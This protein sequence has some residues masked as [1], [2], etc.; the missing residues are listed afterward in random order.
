MVYESDFYTTRRPYS[1]SSRP[2]VSSYSV[3]VRSLP[4][5]PYTA[6]R[7]LVTIVRTVP[8]RIYHA[9]AYWPVVKTIRLHAKV[10]PSIIAAELNRI[11]YLTRPSFNSYVEQYLNSKGFTDFD[12]EAKDIRAKTAKLLRNIHV[13]VPR[14]SISDYDEHTLP[15]RLRSDDYVRRI[16][17]A[18]NARKDIESLPWYSSPQ[19]RS[20]GEGHLACIKYAGGRP[21]AKRRS[22]YT[23]G[24]LVPGDVKSDVKLMSYYMKNR[25]AAEDACGKQYSKPTSWRDRVP[26]LYEDPTRKKIIDEEEEDVWED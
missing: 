1:S 20:I 25:K 17:N 21:Q 22:Y 24:D 14:P 2:Y 11:R 26:E 3:T 5:M 7:K 12:D 6:H 15:E 9:G 23:V 10:R 13:F 18:K 4:H 16:I 19:K 8:V